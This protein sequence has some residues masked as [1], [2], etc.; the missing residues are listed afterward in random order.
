MTNLRKSIN[1]PNIK[2]THAPMA[3]KRSINSRMRLESLFIYFVSSE[4][5]MT[6]ASVLT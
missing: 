3:M 6:K 1:T 5:M 2:A 4:Y